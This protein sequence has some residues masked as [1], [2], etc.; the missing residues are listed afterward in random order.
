MSELTA[1]HL[2]T[3]AW[4][5]H[6]A[7]LD[8]VKAMAKELTDARA[9]IAE[10]E[11]RFADPEKL[12]AFIAAMGNPDVAPRGSAVM[13]STMDKIADALGTWMPGGERCQATTTV[14]SFVQPP[15]DRAIWC[16]LPRGHAGHHH[17]ELWAPMNTSPVVL[18]WPEV[19]NA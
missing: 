5:P 7:S 1:K 18:D 8:E 10:M 6:A 9:R 14:G 19:P 11:D 2:E 15:D 4:D 16:N 13:R 17:G 12:E 3:F